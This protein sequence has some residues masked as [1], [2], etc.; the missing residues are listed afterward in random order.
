M[1]Q[2][3]QWNRK[4]HWTAV[5]PNLHLW[6]NAIVF[7]FCLS[8]TFF[9]W[10][11]RCDKQNKQQS[12]RFLFYIGLFEYSRNI[13]FRYEFQV[14][15]CKISKIGKCDFLEK[16]SL[17]NFL[18]GNKFWEKT[19]FRKLMKNFPLNMNAWWKFFMFQ[20]ISLCMNNFLHHI[21]GP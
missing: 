7:I 13:Y 1:A 16:N 18:S 9:Y 21:L 19:L 14:F 2:Y 12:N 4:S 17:L 5:I 10:I 20:Y 6:M 8:N 11:L 3:S 15:L